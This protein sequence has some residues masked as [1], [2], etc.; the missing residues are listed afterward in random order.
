MNE[1]EFR[2]NEELEEGIRLMEHLTFINK[3]AKDAVA[4]GDGTL[5]EANDTYETLT[6]I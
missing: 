1:I 3:K 6:G 4:L 2:S 5:K